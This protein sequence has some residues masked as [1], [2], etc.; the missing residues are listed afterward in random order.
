MWMILPSPS[1][2]VYLVAA[3]CPFKAQIKI[4]DGRLD[5][6]MEGCAY[7]VKSDRVRVGENAPVAYFRRHN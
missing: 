2:C 1:V 6:P 7:N 5:T 4:R 3:P